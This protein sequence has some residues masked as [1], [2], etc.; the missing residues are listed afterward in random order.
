MKAILVVDMPTKCSECELF[1]YS[2]DVCLATRKMVDKDIVGDIKIDWCPLKPM[3]EK[4]EAYAV[5]HTEIAYEF[6][7]KTH[8]LYADGWNACLEAIGDDGEW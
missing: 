7:A 3:P 4:K 6:T 1:S 2:N 8:P 5:S